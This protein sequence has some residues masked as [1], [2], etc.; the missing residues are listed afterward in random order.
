MSG[1][2]AKLQKSMKPDKDIEITKLYKGKV[3]V[4]FYP[5]SHQYWVSIDEENFKRKTGV[6][7]YIGI[8]DKSRP[9]ESWQQQVTADYLLDLVARKKKIDVDH[10]LEAVVQCEVLRG[11]SADI[12]KEIHGWVEK[13]VRNKLKQPGYE[14][15]PDMPKFPEAITGVNSFFE[16]E[17]K[18]KVKFVSTEKPVYSMEHDYIGTED[19]TFVA[20]E[21]FCDADI[22]SSN[23]L[24]NAVRLQTAAYTKARTEEG[25]RK[26]QGRWA[27]RFSKYTEE[28]YL[29]R[30]ARKQEIKRAIARI[31]GKEQKE[32]AIQPYQVFEAKF[33][34]DEKGH[35]D[36]DFNAFL[37]FKAGYEWNRE[38]DPF[39]NG[40]NW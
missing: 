4:K 36:R 1:V 19:M 7:S 29:R 22:K 12:G 23:G 38:T 31:K 39:Y 26:S 27:I 3:V 8:K 24:Y 11:E 33:L 32:Y 25:G 17:K 6:T 18:H 35:L 20:D 14:T 13:Y 37:S 9:L 34:D 5:I 10:I 15:L 40:A 2:P 21:L 16:W 30:E 28:E